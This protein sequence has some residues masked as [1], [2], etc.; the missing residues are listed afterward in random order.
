MYPPRHQSNVRVQAQGL[1]CCENLDI[2]VRWVVYVVGTG[3]FTLFLSPPGACEIQ[4]IRM[5]LV[6]F[7]AWSTTK[8]PVA[9]HRQ[10]PVLRRVDSARLDW[11]L[12]LVFSFLFATKVIC[13]I[14]HRLQTAEFF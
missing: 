6:L 2:M 5:L 7:K 8:I 11:Y 4:L 9:P 12:L 13:G 3:D 10:Q 14:A 1:R